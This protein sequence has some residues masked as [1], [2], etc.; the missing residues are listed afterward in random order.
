M[1]RSAISFS[2]T[3]L[4]SRNNLLVASVTNLIG[5]DGRQRGRGQAEGDGR[6]DYCRSSNGR[7]WGDGLTGRCTGSAVQ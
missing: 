4:N 5:R 7:R 2:K 6:D 3:S 1:T